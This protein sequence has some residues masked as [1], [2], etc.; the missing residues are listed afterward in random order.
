MQTQTFA[1]CVMRWTVLGWRRFLRRPVL[2]R[3]SLACRSPGPRLRLAIWARRSASLSP[4][5]RLHMRRLGRSQAR[6]G[7][8]A[9]PRP[10][11]HPAARLFFL[12]KSKISRRFKSWPSALEELPNPE[13]YAFAL[14]PAR[15]L[16]PVHGPQWRRDAMPK[17][18]WLGLAKPDFRKA[19]SIFRAA[20]SDVPIRIVRTLPP[21]ERRTAATP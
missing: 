1:A 7:S 15:A 19:Q 4:L 17:L 8:R 2:S 3:L 5:A 14:M 20:G 16:R 18:F 13:I 6:C 9:F 11:Y 21:S 10:P 12:S